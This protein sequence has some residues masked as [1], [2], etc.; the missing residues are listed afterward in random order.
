MGP[1]RLQGPVRCILQAAHRGQLGAPDSTEPCRFRGRPVRFLGKVVGDHS[2]ERPYLG[3][4]LRLWLLR[5]AVFASGPRSLNFGGRLPVPPGLRGE[6]PAQAADPRCAVTALRAPHGCAPHLPGR[7]GEGSARA[8][9][10]MRTSP[11]TEGKCHV[12]GRTLPTPLGPQGWIW[13]S[14]LSQ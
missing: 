2:P 11:P 12:W 1:A 7:D 5:Q 10:F 13:A 3:T 6:L 14:F 8:G 4:K 9:V